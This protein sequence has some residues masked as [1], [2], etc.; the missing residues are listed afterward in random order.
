MSNNSTK[1]LVM[2][3]LNNFRTNELQLKLLHYEMDHPARVSGNEMIDALSFGHS[4]VFGGTPGHVSNKTLYIAL[5]Y[6][7]KANH[8]NAEA[9]DEIA[10]RLSE[11]EW[12]QERLIHYI[13][14]LDENEAAVIRMTYIDGMTNDQIAESLNTTKRTVY[15]RRNKAIER[16]CDMYDY[17]M[18]LS[19]A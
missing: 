17:T 16:L 4:E 19:P 6:Q 2:P 1:D 18:G 3:M 15:W 14:L 8:V 11:L 10:I 5:N 13:S 9:I 12:Q 7:D